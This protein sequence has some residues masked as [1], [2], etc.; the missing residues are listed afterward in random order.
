MADNLNF[1]WGNTF[2]LGNAGAV[3]G[4]TS[5]F[6][7]TAATNAVI[8]GKFAA[9]LAPQTNAASPTVDGA[10]NAP[11]VPLKPNECCALVYGVTSNGV[12]QLLQG[13]VIAC[14]VGN[15]SVPGLLVNDP[16]FPGAPNDFCPL[17][18]SIVRTAPNASPWT[19]GTS[20]WT[21]TGVAASVFQN[22]AQ[23]PNRPQAS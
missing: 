5:S 22:V 19:P 3:A 15:G 18:Y 8:N 7:S 11:F 1:S 16:Q 13:K 20:S 21:A 10:T 23:L 12:L 4:T 14:G 9:P 6:T 2:N 17:A